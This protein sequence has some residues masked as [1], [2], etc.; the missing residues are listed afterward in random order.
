[1]TTTNG[2]KWTVVILA[3]ALAAMASIHGPDGI[4]G[5]GR[6]AAR[7]D[8]R[9]GRAPSARVEKR[10]DGGAG[11]VSLAVAPGEPLERARGTPVGAAPPGGWLWYDV[12]GAICRD[13]SPTG[14]YVRF[15]ASD[16]LLVYLE[17]GGACIG[18]GFCGY[19]PA[20][21]NQILSGGG[22]TGFASLRG[23]I[24]G[25]QQPGCYSDGVPSGIFDGSNDA[26]P[27]KDW[28]MVYVPYCTGDVFFGTRNDVIV[29]G[30]ATPQQFVGHR[31]MQKFVARLV[32]TFK[33]SIK[34]VVL[35]GSSAGGFG[36]VLNLSM[37]EDS[38]GGEIAVDLVDDSGPSFLD[39]S[40]PVCM[41]KR[42]RDLWG[43][44]DAFPPDCTEC[45]QPDG[46]GLIHITDFLRRKHPSTRVALISSM[47]DEIIRLFYSAGNGDCADFDDA[48]PVRNYLFTLGATFPAEEYTA[49][50]DDLRRTYRATGHFAT[51][52]LG[53][54]QIGSHQHLWRP[55]FFEAAAGGSIARWLTAFLAGQMTHVGP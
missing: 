36:A 21:V 11:F 48:H 14:F 51:Y 50:L 20:S 1:L 5:A 22:K 40:M 29:P 2:R 24:A 31:N 34:R 25:R 15:T 27:F 8:R 47:Q 13:G 39:Q 18:P 53:G 37:V 26:N 16:K 44:D 7:P 32:P 28:N 33:D 12:A 9:R 54:A 23:A 38:F 55:S 41:Q 52:Y 6:S 19:N 46:G 10:G 49:G 42:W 17:G 4:S 35:S 43:F 30:L 3:V 45:F